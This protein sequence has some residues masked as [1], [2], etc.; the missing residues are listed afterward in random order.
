M[1]SINKSLDL[2]GN[3]NKAEMDDDTH[4]CMSLATRMRR[5]DPRRKAMARSSIENVLFDLESGF[6]NPSCMPLH[7]F[8]QN[9]S[10]PNNG[11]NRDMVSHI[12]L[13]T[14]GDLYQEL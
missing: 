9:F 8:S 5:L 1:E 7:G 2:F 13:D 6:Q 12:S 3:Q 14:T 10:T 4:Y 11:G